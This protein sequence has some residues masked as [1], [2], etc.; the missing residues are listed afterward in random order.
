MGKIRNVIAREV[1]DSR[2]MP[3]V[4]ADVRLDSGL[5]G[6]A[7][8]PAG[9][10]K[11]K[12][13]ALE[14]R[15]S[16]VSRYLGM[17]VLDAVRN[18]REEIA[19]ALAGKDP[20]QQGKID[21]ALLELDGTG[22]KG[23]LGANS[24]V[25][26]SMAVARAGALAEE[27]PL[28]RYLGDKTSTLLPVPLMNVINGGRHA[29]NSLAM[30]E[31]M[32]VPRGAT[33]FSQA[34]RM[35]SETFQHLKGLLKQRDYATSVGDEGGF[36]PN[37]RSSEEAMDLIVEGIEKAGYRPGEEIALALDPAASEFY[38]DGKYHLDKSSGL[39]KTSDEM[40][41]LY[42]QWAKKYPIVS[43]ED[44]LAEDDWDGWETLTRLIGKKIQVVGDD[45]FVTDPEIIRKGIKKGIGNAVLI[46]L[47]QIGTVTET[48][49]AIRVAR[50]GN[51]RV[52]IS[53]R[54]GETED[55]FIADLA[56]AVNAGQIKAGSLCRSERIVKYN[57]LL[58][59]EEELGTRGR[60]DSPF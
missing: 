45:I 56:V 35:A 53:H 12:R 51:Y 8:A 20:T 21:H 44:G 7:T 46:K 37:V 39:Q 32:I 60:F 16:N 31:F 19:P 14:L 48:L 59:I 41:K 15:D 42:S 58:E 52:V 43:I 25:A 17:G 13:E 49:E 40:V 30:Q 4:Q 54:S 11:G 33:S 18:I 28:Y 26:V 24:I 23:R 38:R 27:L 1:L 6:R 55:S 57:R 34:L 5:V 29:E 22:N 3:T 2:G 50:K 47:N 10:S 36:A 9:A